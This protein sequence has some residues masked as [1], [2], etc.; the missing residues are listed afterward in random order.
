VLART[1][2][3]APTAVLRQPRRGGG[4]ATARTP[5]DDLRQ[6]VHA[7]H[8]GRGHGR[9]RPGTGHGRLRRLSH[10]GRRQRHLPT[11]RLTHGLPGTGP[12]RRGQRRGTRILRR[13]PCRQDPRPGGHRDRTLHPRRPPP[14]RRT[15]PGRPHALHVR[16]VH[17]S[18]AQP[19]RARSTPHRHVA[20]VHR[21]RRRRCPGPDR[22]AVHPAHP[23]DPILRLAPGRPATQ[24]RGVG[25]RAVRPALEG[26]HVLRPTHPRRHP[27]RYRPESPRPHLRLHRSPRGGR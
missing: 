8:L 21:S 12:A 20:P 6:R 26:H 17:G 7:D 5:A 24:R 3:H 1:P 9:H 18:P 4:L 27:H 2:P 15:H 14:T 13:C 22:L 10:P 16:P 23:A 11:P 19:R 25:P